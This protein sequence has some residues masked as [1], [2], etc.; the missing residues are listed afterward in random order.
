MNCGALTE[1]VLA[2]TIIA[3]ETMAATLFIYS[4]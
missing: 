2:E 3:K 4:N 1:N